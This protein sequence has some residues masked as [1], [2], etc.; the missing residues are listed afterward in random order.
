MNDAIFDKID[1]G[2]FQPL[3][4]DDDITDISYCNH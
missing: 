2:L 3:I 1:F 4:D